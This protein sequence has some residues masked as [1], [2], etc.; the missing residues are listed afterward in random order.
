[1]K[2]YA[3]QGKDANGKRCMELFTGAKPNACPVCGCTNIIAGIENFS[4]AQR[5]LFQAIQRQRN[6]ARTLKLERIK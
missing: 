1:M 4:Y 6:N 2:T 3:C 5:Q